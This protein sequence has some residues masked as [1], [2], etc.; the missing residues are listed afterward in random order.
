MEQHRRTSDYLQKLDIEQYLDSAIEKYTAE[1]NTTR[2]LNSK[3]HYLLHNPRLRNQHKQAI[4]VGAL[5]RD[6]PETLAFLG[7]TGLCITKT[8]SPKKSFIIGSLPIAKIIYKTSAETFP[9]VWLPIA[10]DIAITPYNLKGEEKLVS[11][12][13][14]NIGSLTK[15]LPSKVP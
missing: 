4:K 1:I 5:K 12:D 11:M 13:D 3:E 6:S 10:H 14:L 15:Q 8:V 7:N 2:P 9:G